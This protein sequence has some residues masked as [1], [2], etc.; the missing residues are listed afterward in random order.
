MVRKAIIEMAKY[1]I[2]DRV[3][4]PYG[5]TGTI[6]SVI[7][8]PKNLSEETLEKYRVLYLNFITR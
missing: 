3:Y 4:L 1:K 5:Y 6:T 8:M 2:G 7:E